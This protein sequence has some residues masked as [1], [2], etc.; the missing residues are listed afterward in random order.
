MSV[1]FRHSQPFLLGL[2]G[3]TGGVPAATGGFA[4]PFPFIFGGAGT[5][6]GTPVITED[7]YVGFHVNLGSMMVRR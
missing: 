4:A 3:N 7:H 1:A 5:S 6:S 2:A